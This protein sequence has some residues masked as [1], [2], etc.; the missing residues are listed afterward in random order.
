M[1]CA[2]SDVSC[3]AGFWRVFQGLAVRGLQDSRAWGFLGHVP[4]VSGQGFWGLGFGGDDACF[5]KGI[6]GYFLEFERGNAET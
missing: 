5:L 1:S 6:G 3:P 4:G 2:Y